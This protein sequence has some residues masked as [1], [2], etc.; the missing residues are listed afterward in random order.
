MDH[1]K[2]SGIQRSLKK[3][4]KAKPHQMVPLTHIAMHKVHGYPPCCVLPESGHAFNVWLSLQ[5]SASL[6]YLHQMRGP[7]FRGPLWG[8]ACDW[9]PAVT[10]TG[11]WANP[12]SQKVNNANKP[13]VYWELWPK[14]GPAYF[15]DAEG[16]THGLSDSSKVGANKNRAVPLV[17]IMCD[18]LDLIFIS[19]P[20]SKLDGEPLSAALCLSLTSSFI[21]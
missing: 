14:L 4:H 10:A 7:L 8:C 5:V 6:L 3:Y 2:M 16:K 1:F 12:S 20:H 21:S 9:K 17:S 13:Q 15:L 11:D 18:L 19:Y